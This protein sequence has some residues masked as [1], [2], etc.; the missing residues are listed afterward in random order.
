MR[1]LRKDMIWNVGRRCLW[2]GSIGAAM[3]GTG[4]FAQ[5]ATT[6]VHEQNAARLKQE[7]VKLVGACGPAECAAPAGVCD[8]AAGHAATAGLPTRRAPPEREPCTGRAGLGPT[9]TAIAHGDREARRGTKREGAGRGFH[10][11]CAGTFLERGIGPRV[12]P[13]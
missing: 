5:D 3:T 7:Y 6:A 9:H 12:R 8:D 10:A 11:A 4:A 1:S 2:A 13:F